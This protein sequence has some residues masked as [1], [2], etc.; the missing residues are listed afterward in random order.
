MAVTP[1]ADLS[2]VSDAA[3]ELASGSPAG[4]A[5]SGT[6]RDLRA[7]ILATAHGLLEE[8]GAAA[9]SLREVARRAGVTHQAP[10][11]HFGDRESILG[12]LVADGFDELAAR[13]AAAN[14]TAPRHGGRG[15][16]REAH[17]AHAGFA[18]ARPGLFRI[19]FR[20]DTCDPARFPAVRAAAARVTEEIAWLTRLVTGRPP[21]PAMTDVL[22]A[23][24]HG[25]ACL[26]LDLPFAAAPARDALARIDDA[27]E[28]F[29]DRVLRR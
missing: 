24:L 25:V 17:R 29:A 9:L 2:P 16:I 8:R 21:E 5:A 14:A 6:P 26:V 28:A 15:V 4:G 12:V 13:L 10:Y 20:P 22:C 1:A 27:A 18:L 11:H 7:V 23:Q 3:D 19:L